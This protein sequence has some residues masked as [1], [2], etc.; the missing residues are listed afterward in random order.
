MAQYDEF[1]REI[2][3]PTPVPP[4]PGYRTPMT[5]TEQIKRFIRTELS[6]RAAAEEYETFE[7][8]EDFDVD[9][10]P[11][12]LSAYELPEGHVEW[13]GGVKD[14]DGDPPIDPRDKTSPRGSKRVPEASVTGRDQTPNPDK[15]GNRGGDAAE[16]VAA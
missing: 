4:P 13:P 9:E 10:D 5:L 15:S 12:P 1:G 11:D 16:A 7:E 8:S 6:Q 2:P 14:A 3:D